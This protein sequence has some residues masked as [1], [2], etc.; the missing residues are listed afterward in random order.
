[1]PDPSAA[2]SDEHV[3]LLAREILERE[4]YRAFRAESFDMA[5]WLRAAF[6]SFLTFIGDLYEDNPALYWLLV[7]SLGALCAGLLTHVVWTLLGA[8]RAPPESQAEQAARVDL[9]FA[10]EAQALAERGLHLEAA[11]RL[12]LSSLRQ[13]ARRRYIPLHPEDGNG[14]VC[15]QLATSKLPAALKTQLIALIVQTE[16]AWYGQLRTSHDAPELY[17]R[18]QAAH[19]A[20]SRSEL[21]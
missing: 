19:T 20:L 6:G 7:L 10:G 4:P 3:R 12:L 18:W 13:L 8:F 17:R 14:A 16:H 9:D 15:R 21:P 1:M 2:T 5:S 11:H